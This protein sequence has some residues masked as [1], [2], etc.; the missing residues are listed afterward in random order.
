M[1]CVRD[2]V[3][4]PSRCWCPFI[5]KHRSVLTLCAVHYKVRKTYTDTH[6]R[7]YQL[8]PTNTLCV[9]A[10]WSRIVDYFGTRNGYTFLDCFAVRIQ[11]AI[12]K[13]NFEWSRLSIQT[14]AMENIAKGLLLLLCNAHLSSIHR[15]QYSNAINTR[16]THNTFCIINYIQF[17]ARRTMRVFR[18][19]KRVIAFCLLRLPAQKN[20]HNHGIAPASREQTRVR[21]LI[22]A[23]FVCSVL[24]Q[25]TT[26]HAPAPYKVTKS[27]THCWLVIIRV[28]TYCV[29]S[30]EIHDARTYARTHSRK[31]MHV[32]D[33]VLFCAFRK[34]YLCAHNSIRKT[35]L[36]FEFRATENSRRTPR[37]R[38]KTLMLLVRILFYAYHIHLCM[39]HRSKTFWLTAA[40]IVSQLVAHCICVCYMLSY[41]SSCPCHTHMR[42]PPAYNR[43]ANKRLVRT[44]N[45]E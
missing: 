45:C 38:E 20:V 36:Y 21:R 41:I 8:Q 5:H 2:C 40:R 23:P 39:F 16:I 9:R 27:C 31:R 13:W 44:Q 19:S 1:P 26:A 18:S 17:T 22:K 33:V 37:E 4:F 24:V 15:V 34:C 6:E 14:A 32:D 43:H 30:C 10:S 11:N 29:Y 25:T 35:T 42:L 7:K 12:G 3:L 28:Y